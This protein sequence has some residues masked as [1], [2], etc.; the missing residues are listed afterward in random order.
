MQNKIAKVL[1][2]LAGAISLYAFL[3]IRIEPLYN[4][5]LKEKILTDYWENTKYGELYYY[6]NFIT[7][8]QEKNLPPSAPKYRNTPKH[9]H[10]NDADILTYGDSFFDF[11]RMKTFPERLGDTLHKRVFY[12]R[13][14][15]DHRPVIYMENDN[16]ANSHA[17]VL[18]YET[19]ERFLAHRFLRRHD[20]IPSVDSRSNVRKMIS[21]AK[22][23]LFIKDSELKY[24]VLMQRSYVSTEIYS[25]INTFKFDKFGYISESTPVYAFK[26][27]QPWLFGGDEVNNDNT[28]F[29]YKFTDDEI[30]T[31]C[32]NI[33]D[34]AS[35]L[36]RKYDLQLVFMPIPSKYVIYHRLINNDP[37]TNYLPRIYAGLEQ[38]KVPVVKLYEPYLEAKDTLYYFTDNHWNKNGVD[39]A[40]DEA[41]K[42]M[43]PYLQPELLAADSI[44]C[45]SSTL[46]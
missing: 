36:K 27:G 10:I 9:P 4:A 40:L 32:D 14:V 12:Q 26:N 37:Y 46:Q 33:A 38:R 6:N 39:L 1:V 24:T 30:N 22:N 23:W 31:I 16:Y 18:L 17:R 13:M 45:K 15:D 11:T 29:Y 35:V 3:A 20:T 41:L 42:V 28:S 25:A 21:A 34:L 5:V 2:Y 44:R 43:N 7:H 19:S 8:F